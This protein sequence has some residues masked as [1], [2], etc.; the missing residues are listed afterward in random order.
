MKLTWLF[1]LIVLSSLFY[2]QDPIILTINEDNIHKSEFEQIYWKNKKEKTATKE[3]LDEYIKLFV[4]F[5]LKVLAAE[6]EG[7][8]TS[9]KFINE[10][11]GYRIQLEK[12]YLTDT[13]INEDLLKEAYYRTANEVNASHIMTKLPSNPSPSDTIRAWKKISKLRESIV[14]ENE[15]FEEVAFKFSEDQSAKNNKGNLGYFNAF[16]MIYTFEDAAYN[17]NVG[18]VSKIV[19]TRYGYHILKVNSFRKAKGE[20]RTSHI[21]IAVDNKNKADNEKALIEINNIHQ[22]LIDGEKFTEL[23]LEKSDDRNSAKKG[24]DL[25]W[26]SSSSSFYKEFKDAV[27]SLQN[28]GD[29][30]KPFRSPNGWHIVKRMG[31]EPIKDYD[32]L[33]YELKNKIQKDARSQKTISS[34]I[35]KLKKEYQLQNKLNTTEISSILKNKNFNNENIALNKNIKNVNK[36]CLSFANISF[37]NFDFITYINKVGAIDQCIENKNEISRIFKNF[38]NKKLIEYEKTQLQTKYPEFKALLKEYRDGIL[39]F[40]ISDKK[41]WTKAIKDTLGLKEFYKENSD[42]WIW[43]DRIKAEYFTSDSKKQIKKVYSLKKKGEI[44]NDSIINFANTLDGRTT[45]KSE[46]SEVS[47]TNNSSLETISIGLQKPSYKDGKWE[48][49]NIVEAIPSRPKTLEEAEGIVVSAYQN[50]LE[51]RWLIE[52]KAKN[53]IKVHYKTLYTINEK[54]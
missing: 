50:E 22:K 14:N 7:L 41:I 5:K 30:S 24:G 49:I 37:S 11:T 21:M 10:L 4:N 12:P 33:K 1:S 13:S 52:L 28:D 3:D 23:A 46:I 53:K 38:I 45:F 6:N 19:R 16:K 47:S 54:P 31:F 51:N 17:T 43:P 32:E 8:D 25:G 15:N 39:L 27:F 20:I 34:F 2:A 9:K 36:T 42:K 48:I 18:E 40:E 44:S 26:I 29:F 35:E